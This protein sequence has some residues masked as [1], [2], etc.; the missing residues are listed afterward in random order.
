MKQLV[1][2]SLDDGTSVLVEV[3]EPETG[4][5]VRAGRA[6]EIVEKVQ[7]TFS[8]A[9]DRVKPAAETIINK[10]RT[11]DVTPDEIQVEFGIKLSAEAGAFFASAST[12][13]NFAITLSW[14]REGK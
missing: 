12:E 10:L 3:D 7:Y 2:F 14:K 9:L 1:E 5:V 4:G 6:G 13:A 8:E 11:L